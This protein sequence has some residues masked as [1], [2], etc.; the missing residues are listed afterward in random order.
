MAALGA[1]ASWRDAVA[2]PLQATGGLDVDLVVLRAR[3]FTMDVAQPRVEAFAVSGGR[4][5]AVGSSEDVRNLATRRTPV[6]DAGGATVLPGFVD[7][8]CH[9]SGV[10]E[11]FGVLTNLRAKRE[12]LD[13]LRKKAATTPPG[14]WV[15]GFLYDDTKVAE[16]P[17]TRRDLDT[18][19]REH[20]ISVAHRGGHT[21]VYN[22][23][24]FE[25]AG[26]SRETADPKGGR[27]ERDSAGELTG[28][29]AELARG[30]FSRA[31][32]RPVLSA[33]EQRR[34]AQAGMKH[35]SERLVAT[36]LTTVHDASAGRERILAYEDAR[37]AG[38]LK[39]RVYMMVAGSLLPAFKNAGL[40]T[41]FGDEWIRIGGVKFVADGSASERTMYMS[42]P[43]EGRTDRGI[44]TM[45]QAEIDEAVEDAHRHNF[46]IGIHANGDS[47]IDMVLRAYERVL[48][49]WPHPDRR[50]RIEHCSLVNPDLLRRIK[51]TGSI[52]TPFWTYV[53]YHGEKW[54]EYGDERMKWM[55]AHRSFL[56]EGIRV[57]GASDY[58]PGP[59]EPLMAIQ[60]MVTRRDYAGRTWGANQCV[61]VDEAL[62]IATLHGAYASY[63]EKTKG[64]ITPGKLADFVML[65][66]DPHD[67]PPEEIQKIR[68]LRTVVGGE[69]KYLGTA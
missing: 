56:D 63:E 27:F 2:A 52:P 22:S 46:Q 9:P 68:I 31:G 39:H 14:E 37:R 10:A 48:A 34:R 47:T 4:F 8:H 66:K 5:V 7:A 28:K 43:Y 62:R 50:H 51:A 64:S 13:A 57:P 20:P 61:T 65:E 17:I 36:G 60:S 44:L 21:T 58:P 15:E 55:F 69:T 3:V 54:K 19:S 6:L 29:V 11:L 45:T 24:A 12:I 33:D 59:F 23:K 49:R 25:L 40:Y 30:V 32:K 67:V 53:Y 35:M 1:G 18:V 41:G 16:G 42:A 38:D 26:V